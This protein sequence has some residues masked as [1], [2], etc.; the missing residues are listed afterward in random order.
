MSDPA[1]DLLSRIAR[2]CA[3]TWEWRDEEAVR[4]R[5][6]TP[7]TRN[8]GVIAQDVEAVFPE[9]VSTDSDGYKH[10]DYNG[11]VALLIE[12]VKELD[13]RLRALE[14]TNPEG[15]EVDGA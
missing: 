6:L 3:V 4:V 1:S 9:L 11:L 5:G 14:E 13:S 12:A 10:V 2:I 15:G 8:A 7:G